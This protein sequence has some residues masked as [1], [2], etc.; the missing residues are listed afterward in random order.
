[1]SEITGRIRFKIPQQ[2]KKGGRGRKDRWKKKFKTLVSV[3]A[4]WWIQE[5]SIILALLF[6]FQNFII[7]VI[8]KDYLGH[9]ISSQDFIYFNYILFTFLVCQ[10]AIP[11]GLWWFLMLFSVTSPLISIFLA[12]TQLHSF[13]ITEAPALYEKG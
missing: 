12:T 13:P 9:I 2:I 6:R 10:T 8:L 3:E 11:P 7:K 4:A 5:E 1:M